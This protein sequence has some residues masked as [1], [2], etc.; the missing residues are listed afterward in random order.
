MDTTPRTLG[1]IAVNAL[2]FVLSLMALGLLGV[3]VYG[4]ILDDAAFLLPIVAVLAVPA[5][6]LVVFTTLE[7][8]TGNTPAVVL[9]WVK[10]LHK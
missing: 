8:I 9:R 1:T 3:M 4:M 10:C 2:F 7:L 6:G 5:L